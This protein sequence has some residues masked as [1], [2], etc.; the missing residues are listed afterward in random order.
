[1]CRSPC[2]PRPRLTLPVS[3]TDCSNTSSFHAALNRPYK[4][5]LPLPPP[6]ARRTSQSKFSDIKR[7]STA[8]IHQLAIYTRLLMATLINF[9]GRQSNTASLSGSQQMCGVTFKVFILPSL[10]IHL[11]IYLY[12]DRSLC[13]RGERRN[14]EGDRK[15]IGNSRRVLFAKWVK[16]PPQKMKSEG[17]GEIMACV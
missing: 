17:K 1:M 15:R 11:F 4:V 12:S 8:P 5:A 16:K 7:S 13:C 3:L 9:T 14:H 6:D 10:F 2:A